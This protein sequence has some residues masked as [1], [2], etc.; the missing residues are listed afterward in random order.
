MLKTAA[1]VLRH[2]DRL[3]DLAD[4]PDAFARAAPKLVAI[5]LL[6]AATFGIAVGSYRGGV[7]IAY[8]AVKMPL[9]LGIP[10]VVSLPA[11]R[12]LYA[13][14]AVEAP[15]RRVAMAGLV[16]AARTAVLAAALGPVVWLPYSV[17]IDYH[18]AVLLLCGALVVAGAPGLALVSRA[19]PGRGEGRLLATVGSILV[20][21]FTI[22][23]TGWVLR[24]FI[25]RPNAEVTL[26]RPVESD[27]L[28]AIGATATA[29]VGVYQDWEPD[30]A[31]FAGRGFRGE[32]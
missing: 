1:D 3:L 27:V 20:L 24:P 4:A 9:L 19:L 14:C 8:A 12:A 22:A 16:G 31:G 26:L 17:T 2:P 21:G 5:A 29:S 13:A 28:S 6:G 15:W 25:A 11:V 23:Q 30:P 10:L 32:E 18:A 7:Q